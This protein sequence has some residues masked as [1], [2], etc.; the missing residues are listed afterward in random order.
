MKCRKKSN[1]KFV[2]RPYYAPARMSL[3][4]RRPRAL[5]HTLTTSVAVLICSFQD[6][7]DRTTCLLRVYHVLTM[8][9]EILQIQVY[10]V[11]V[12]IRSASFLE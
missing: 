8:L 1:F 6:L 7:L 11:H 12:F 2:L 4:L 5:D 3:R 10:T 9:F